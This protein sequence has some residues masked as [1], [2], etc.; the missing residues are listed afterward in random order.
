MGPVTLDTF[1]QVADFLLCKRNTIWYK[2]EYESK[3]L[4]S[5]SIPRELFSAKILFLYGCE[6]EEWITTLKLCRGL[7][8]LILGGTDIPFVKSK[9]D[10]LLSSLPTTEFWITN[11]LGNHPRC[12]LLPLFPNYSVN[13]EEFQRE[14]R[15]LFGIP[16]SRI[17]SSARIEFYNELTNLESIHPYFMKELPNS[18]YQKAVASLYFCCCPMGNGFD[19][20]R[21]WESLYFGAIPI[22]KNHPFYDCLQYYYPDIP[23]ILIEEWKDLPACVEKLSI[24]QYNEKSS[25]LEILTEKYWQDLIQSVFVQ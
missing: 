19:T 1:I 13:Y 17:N 18:L 12:K 8:L 22:V 21:F 20:H 10:I 24:E 4:Y 14:K 9:L 25:N 6:V 15:N 3:I 16:F 5:D 11:W 7:K 2:K 23:M